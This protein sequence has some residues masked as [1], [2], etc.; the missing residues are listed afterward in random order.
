VSLVV[1]AQKLRVLALEW[2]DLL[3]DE[4]V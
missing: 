2:L 1:L 4:V 3:F